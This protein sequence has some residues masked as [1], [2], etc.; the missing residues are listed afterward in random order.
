TLRAAVDWSYDLLSEPE[1][2]L[3]RRLAVFTGGWTLEAVET[4]CADDERRTT[5]DEGR[6]DPLVLR[7]SSYLLCRDEVIDLLGRLMDRSLAVAETEPADGE[8][9]YR[10][11]ETIRQ[12]A[13]EK[14]HEAG[15]TPV[16]RERH[17]R[18]FLAL[19]EQAEAGMRGPRE[20]ACLDQLELEHGNLRAALA[21][22]Q[23]RPGGPAAG[24]GDWLGL[25]PGWA[26]LTF[27]GVHNSRG[28]G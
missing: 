16:V 11:L 3:L 27:W 4:V 5:N 10:L 1:R 18:Y 15:E 13:H 23:T 28:Q 2:V 6:S 22:S 9:R 7:P 12:Y 24:E 17:L 8:V 20:V 19:A 21:W 25:R 14:L 26:V